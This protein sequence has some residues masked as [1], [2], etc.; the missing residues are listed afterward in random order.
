MAQEIERKFWVQSLPDEINTAE[1]FTI[2]QGY[3][4]AEKEGNEVRLREISGKFYL[5][6]K[7]AGGLVREELETEITAAQFQTLWPGT[8]GRQIDKVRYA[9]HDGDNL[10]EVDEYFGN[11]K[12]L[13]VAEVEFPDMVKSEAFI[14]AEWMGKELTEMAEL[15][16]KALCKEVSFADLKGLLA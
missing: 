1:R 10:I 7:N 9:F 15:R 8:A 4:A 11:L 2:R 5:T 13:I 6:V 14:P 3:L 16:N 12:G